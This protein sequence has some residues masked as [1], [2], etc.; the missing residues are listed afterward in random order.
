MKIV[1]LEVEGKKIRLAEIEVSWKGSL[2]LTDCHEYRFEDHD[3]TG[4]LRRIIG[5]SD[6]VVV[7]YLGT[8]VS[9]RL[10]SLP[11]T[12]QKKIEQVLPYEVELQL[13][14]ELEQV[15]LS[16]HMV[17]LNESSSR[18]MAAVTPKEEFRRFIQELHRLG[19]DP[20]QV[21]WDGMALFNFSRLAPEKET[22]VSLLLK[23]GEEQ[24]LLC[25][26]K[27]DSPLM[28]RSIW[29]GTKDLSEK[30]S[31]VKDHSLI[32][33]LLKTI[34]AFKNELEDSPHSLRVCG[35][36][37]QIKGLPEWI[38]IELMLPLKDW[39]VDPDRFKIGPG[40]SFNGSLMNPLYISAI[41]L[42]LKGSPL[43]GSLSQINFRKE[44]F[45][46]ATVEKG[47]KGIQRI[48]VVFSLIII[49]LGLVDL[50]VR[51]S[52]KKDHYENVSR[53]LQKE[54]RETFPGSGP[55]ISEIDQAKGAITELKKREA[56]F[57][58]NGPTS[59]DILRE[60]TVQIPKEVKIDVNEL[61]VEPER[62]RLE[63]ETDSFEALDKIK[64]S[65][66]KSN[67]FG[68]MTVSDSKMNAEES[69]VRFK[70]EIIRMAR[71][72]KR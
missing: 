66:G 17:D 20:H 64:E 31:W 24:T 19:I 16:Y 49:M 59:L 8:L 56:F 18:I 1:G 14:F 26:F 46:H 39:A 5:R 7:S 37:G 21:E 35:E 62:I 44:E 34:Q 50:G 55:I 52:I 30:K 9:S 10:L 6:Q 43:R 67:T 61:L 53:Q 4:I 63:A 28:I 58:M 2:T 51:Y 72:E 41:G 69:K 3:T 12:Q 65:L 48:I 29:G 23:I 60:I 54:Y 42:A 32:R 22:T 33:E 70:L 57:K 45:S 38:S 13:P 71:D 15:I 40:V 25:F 47:K 36:G 11:F 68:E 27:G